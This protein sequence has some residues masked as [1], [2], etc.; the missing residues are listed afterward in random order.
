MQILAPDCRLKSFIQSNTTKRRRLR[1]LLVESI[2]TSC[3]A[4]Y[5]G[6]KLTLAFRK[7]HEGFCS[8]RYKMSTY[9]YIITYSV[10]LF[11]ENHILVRTSLYRIH[12]TSPIWLAT[13]PGRAPHRSAR[14]TDHSRAAGP[15]ASP[16]RLVG[17]SHRP[18][19]LLHLLLIAATKNAP[20][21]PARPRHYKYEDFSQVQAAPRTFN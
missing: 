16:T 1:P 5:R 2:L 9:A 13:V 11:F 18:R 4:Q 20:L 21:A 3:R 6:Q 12:S 10:H 7:H 15:G 8:F 17:N 19:H 14:A